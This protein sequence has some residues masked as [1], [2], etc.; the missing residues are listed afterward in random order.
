MKKKGKWLQQVAEMRAVANGKI[1]T[2]S[3]DEREKKRKADERE[4]S[5]I[6]REVSRPT[7][8]YFNPATGNTICFR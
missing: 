1:S 6:C 2:K 5:R 7:G 4:Y 8:N 3:A